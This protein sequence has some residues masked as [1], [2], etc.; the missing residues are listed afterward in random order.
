MALTELLDPMIT[1][2]VNVALEVVLPTAMFNPPGVDWNVSATVLGSSLR[3]DRAGQTARVRGGQRQ[4]EVGRILVIGSSED[5]LSVPGQ[6]DTGWV[7]QLRGQCSC[8][9]V[10]DRAEAGRFPSWGSVADPEN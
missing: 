7:W 8:V 2:R 5:P 6:L 1:F 10:Q 4:R 9:R 3:V